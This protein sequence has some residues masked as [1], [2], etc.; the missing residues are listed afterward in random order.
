MWVAI[1]IVLLCC[2]R[3]IV[4][5][6]VV[7]WQSDA[8]NALCSSSLRR[9]GELFERMK[10]EI[11]CRNSGSSAD[12]NINRTPPHIA[13]GNEWDLITSCKSLLLE[14]KQNLTNRIL[15]EWFAWARGARVCV[16]AVWSFLVLYF[17][18][19]FLC[20]F[21]YS[22]VLLLPFECLR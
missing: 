18:F 12:D 10:L 14:M 22:V 6:L 11:E 4:Y 5:N 17:I 20:S 13:N 15:A 8:I 9:M 7:G 19:G 1:V 21:V 2:P 16:R 3:S